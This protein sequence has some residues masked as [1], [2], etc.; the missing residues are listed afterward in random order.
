MTVLGVSLI[1]VEMIEQGEKKSL[2]M[3]YTS[4]EHS[5]VLA[6][7]REGFWVFQAWG[8]TRLSPGSIF[9]ERRFQASHLGRGKALSQ[10][11]PKAHAFPSKTTHHNKIALEGF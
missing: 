9:D 11:I 1:D 10:E 7:G 5:F 8:G 2:D 3:C 6:I 4:F